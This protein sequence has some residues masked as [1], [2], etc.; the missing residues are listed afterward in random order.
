VSCLPL[1]S[2]S[3]TGIWFCEALYFVE[4]PRAE[5]VKTDAASVSSVSMSS[6]ARRARVP[7]SGAS[8]AIDVSAGG[9]HPLHP[10]VPPKDRSLVSTQGSPTPTLGQGGGKSPPSLANTFTNSLNYALRFMSSGQSTP[11]G[12]GL[13][14]KTHHGLLNADGAA[15][16][17]RPHIKYEAMV[18]KHLKISCTAYYAKQFDLLRKRCGV[19][20]VFVKSLSRSSNWQVEGGKSRANF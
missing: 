7:A 18:G 12:T 2:S 4:E 6:L 11:R 17:E 1:R 3:T 20:D 13:S 16:D 5:S 9:L 19:D 10:D 8:S 15:I 14:T